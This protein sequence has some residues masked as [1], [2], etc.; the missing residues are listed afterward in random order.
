MVFQLE[1]LRGQ[2]ENQLEGLRSELGNIRQPPRD[3]SSGGG[4]RRTLQEKL[5]EAQAKLSKGLA[6]EEKE[7]L[8]SLMTDM[9]N[10]YQEQITQIREK[11]VVCLFTSLQSLNLAGQW[12]TRDN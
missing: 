2:Y 7:Q 11:H 8:E 3:D 6:R 12:V 1:V 4:G 10:N 5:K 9:D